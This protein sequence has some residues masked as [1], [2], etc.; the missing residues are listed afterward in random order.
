M[1]HLKS[2]SNRAVS[3][4]LLL[5]VV[6]VAALSGCAVSLGGSSDTIPKFT[7][8]VVDAADVISDSVEQSLS[9]S[10]RAFRV[11]GGPQIA[12]AV[13]STTGDKSIED[14]TID[15]ARE[16]GVGTKSKDDGVV[17]LVAVDDRRLRIEVGSGV[18]GDLTD[19]TAGRIVNDIMVPMLK[20]SDYDGAVVDGAEAVMK[21]WRGEGLP[22]PTTVPAAVT[23]VGTDWVGTVLF[24]FFVLGILGIGLIARLR[25]PRGGRMYGGVW[26]PGGFSGRGGFGGFGGG[27]G[28]GGGGGFS[29]GGASG[30]W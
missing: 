28:G 16:W 7:S 24:L 2:V 30:S 10:L 8:E 1:L 19:V 20:E 4:R 17:I 18:E 27:F 5:A 29:G 9:S 22:T 23:T 21:V 11:S 6:G 25:G 14:Y 13:V 12:V 15:L 3:A 26:M